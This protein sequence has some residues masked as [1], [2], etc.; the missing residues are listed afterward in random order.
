MYAFL[1]DNYF[2]PLY[3]ITLVVSLLR[4]KRYFNT[5]VLKYLPMLIAYT[6]VSEIL[7]YFIRDFDS[8]QIVYQD[9]YQYANYIIFNIY[10]VVFFLYFFY[11]FWKTLKNKD[12]KNIIKYGGVVYVLATLINPFFQNALIF[13]QIYA[14]TIGSIVLIISIFL[15]YHQI[16]EQNGKQ[17]ILLVWISS[18]LFIFNLFFPLISIF[19]RYDYALYEKLGLRQFHYLL[20]VIMNACII[21]GF[22]FMRPIRAPE[23]S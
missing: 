21:L 3:A 18:G 8:F 5:S 14:S 10:D 17:Y 22:L 2:I 11:L 16:R 12:H 20:I 9:K 1:K 4:Y 6:L 13:P 23:D 19:A 7:G 15:Y